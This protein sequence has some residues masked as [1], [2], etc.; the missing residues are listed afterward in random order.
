V[1]NEA[2]EEI[3]ERFF[4][5]EDR[6]LRIRRPVIPAMLTLDCEIIHQDCLCYLMER[7]SL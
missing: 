6:E 3:G 1:R 5:I 7:Y 2:G 4:V